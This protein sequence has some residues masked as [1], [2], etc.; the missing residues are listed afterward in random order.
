VRLVAADD[1]Y[2]GADLT[3]F[4]VGAFVVTDRVIVALMALVFTVGA[5]N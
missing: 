5:F 2:R 1:S 4:V 3:V